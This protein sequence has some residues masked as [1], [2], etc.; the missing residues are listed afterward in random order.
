MVWW[1]V[2]PVTYH[3]SVEPQSRPYII[4]HTLARR[5]ALSLARLLRSTG[6]FLVES[7]LKPKQTADLASLLSAVSAQARL[8]SGDRDQAGYLAVIAAWTRCCPHLCEM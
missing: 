4:S 2:Q 6:R 1:P 8:G 3:R 7:L 5:R